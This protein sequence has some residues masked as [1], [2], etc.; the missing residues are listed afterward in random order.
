V[1]A[2]GYSKEMHDFLSANPGLR[3]RFNHT[4][5]L[6]D[7]NPDEMV[8]IFKIMAK[9]YVVEPEV[10]SSLR[11][12]FSDMYNRRTKDFANGRE[13]RKIFENTEK[14][15]ARRLSA[16]ADR[17]AEDYVKIT[18]E[19]LPGQK[20]LGEQDQKITAALDKLNSMIGLDSV[21]QEIESIA[22]YL[23]IEKIRMEQGATQS[24]LNLHFVFTGNPGTGKTTV[25]RI[26]AEIFNAIGLLPKDKVIET[27]RASLVAGYVGQTAL[28][29]EA[30]IDRAMGQVLF[31]DEAYMLSVSPNSN[32][33][34]QE[35]IDTLLKRMEDDRGKFVVIAAGYKNNM[36]GFIDSNP[37]LAS[38]FTKYIDFPDYT[39]QEMLSIFQH[40]ANQH[41]YRITPEALNLISGYF[42]RICDEKPRGFANGR[43]VRNF[44]QDITQRLSTR[45]S[46]KMK[47]GVKPTQEEL[48]TITIEEIG[49]YEKI[50]M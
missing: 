48:N 39:T 3:S 35:A 44:H 7:Y 13:V 42:Q 37:G 31:I 25:A 26:L 21:K 6:E 17:T 1:I 23:K 41:N 24:L 15:I 9:D 2:A 45:L 8:E 46:N 30:V 11:Q 18:L 27:D 36:Q 14:N 22:D 19:D 43:T 20:E 40:I 29:T 16:K 5:N 33:F 34:G 28:K 12:I 49:Q 10:A 32:D 4:F 38:R 47:S 50:R